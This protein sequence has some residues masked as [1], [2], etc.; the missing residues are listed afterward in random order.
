M[1]KADTV[2]HAY[3]SEI[4]ASYQGEGA[5]AGERHLFVRFAGCNVRCRYCDTPDSLVRTPGCSVDY[6]DGTH[7]DLDNPLTLDQ[8]AEIVERCC[9]CDPGIAM[10]AITGGEPMMQSAFIAR[11]LAERPPPVGCLLETNAL[12]D[13]H[14]DR[15]VPRLAVVSADVKLPSNSGEGD[16]WQQHRRFL[17]RCADGHRSA[18]TRV[19]VKMPVDEHT[20]DADVRRGARMVAEALPEAP[21]F[22]QPI[23]S[24]QSGAWQLSQPRLLHLWRSAVSEAP[25]ATMRPQLHKLTGLR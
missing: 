11:W 18:T 6:P 7:S 4:F 8:L 9:R 3:I 5:C 17:Q 20:S 10:V 15:I 22:V 16:R 23:T 21:L 2:E 25:L 14:L 1:S 19:Y 12:I 24:P 13:S